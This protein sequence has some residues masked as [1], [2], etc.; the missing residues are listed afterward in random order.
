MC[1]VTKCCSARS[2]KCLQ[3]QSHH[4]RCFR[5]PLRGCCF[6]W[7]LPT[8]MPSICH[9]PSLTRPGATLVE[10]HGHK[11]CV[12]RKLEG[13]DQSYVRP[14]DVKRCQASLDQV[15]K[16]CGHSRSCHSSFRHRVQFLWPPG[17]CFFMLHP[18]HCGG[19]QCIA[20]LHPM[21]HW[22]KSIG[23]RWCSC[24]WLN[25]WVYSD[26]KLSTLNAFFQVFFSI[27]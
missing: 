14:C 24:N 18:R 7:T 1:L 27:V 6:Q 9:C 10:N 13:C 26:L 19:P 5:T 15:L 3:N 22:C 23:F 21:I 25:T 4:T 20:T 8:N 16:T 12:D 17:R 11:V 2:N